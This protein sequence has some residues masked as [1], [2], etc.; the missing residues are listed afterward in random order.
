GYTAEEKT[1]IAVRHLIPRQL[2]EHG[3][4]KKHLRFHTKSITHIVREYTHEAGVRNLEREISKICRA[5]AREVVEGRTDTL[6]ITSSRI[7]KYLGSQKFFSEIDTRTQRP[8]VAIGLAYTPQGGDVLFVEAARM[9]GKKQL[10]L[11]GQLGDVMKESA[12]TALSYIRST[13]RSLG[14]E[15]DFFEKS[16]IHIH[17]PEGAVPKDGPSAGVTITTALVS[18]LTGRLPRARVAMT[19]EITL[20]GDVLPVGGIKE[21]CLAAYRSGIKNLIL[22]AR[23]EMD[24]EDVPAYVMKKITFH[25]VTKIEEVLQKSLMD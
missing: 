25:P 11:T 4:T 13:A 22:P 20:R 18:L 7:H 12:Q 16:D 15:P 1:E 17:V 3:L 24:L 14:V 8:G 6:I 2:F 9:P 23:N 5:T 10:I 21:K 19:G